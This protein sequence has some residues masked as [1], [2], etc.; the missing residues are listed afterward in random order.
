MKQILDLHLSGL[1]SCCDLEPNCDADKRDPVTSLL[2]PLHWRPIKSRIVFKILLLT[3]QVIRGLAPSFL[4]EVQGCQGTET[5]S[6]DDQASIT[7]LFVVLSRSV[8]EAPTGTGPPL[9]FHE[10]K[11]LHAL[12]TNHYRLMSRLCLCGIHAVLLYKIWNVIGNEGI[13]SGVV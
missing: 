7:L 12:F 10:A 5:W 13:T 11:I 2:A 6:A 1:N 9:V 4:E 3:S 8:D